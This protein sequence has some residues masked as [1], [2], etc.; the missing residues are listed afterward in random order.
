MKENK[1]YKIFEEIATNMV[2]SRLDLNT[3]MFV[4][5]FAC[6]LPMLLYKWNQMEWNVRLTCE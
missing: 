6:T 5:A 3:Q 2:K 4:R 1:M